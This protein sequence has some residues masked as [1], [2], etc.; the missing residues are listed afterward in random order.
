MNTRLDRALN[1]P[2]TKL[3][4]APTIH[5]VFSE[6][7]G[8][9]YRVENLTCTCIDHKN[10]HICKHIYYTLVTSKESGSCA[11][12]SQHAPYLYICPRCHTAQHTLCY[13]DKEGRCYG[14]LLHMLFD[15]PPGIDRLILSWL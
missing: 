14:C 5:Y 8:Y 10:G 9:T 13:V 2:F 3:S 15:F 6:L 12:C 4:L 11:W 1:Q 7:S